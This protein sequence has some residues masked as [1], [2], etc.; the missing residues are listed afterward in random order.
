MLTELHRGVTLRDGMSYIVSG[1]RIDE[2]G[3]GL[4]EVNLGVIPVVCSW[5]IEEWADFEEMSEEELTGL[6]QLAQ[7]KMHDPKHK[8][9][10]HFMYFPPGVVMS[11]EAAEV[12][13]RVTIRYLRLRSLR[14][15][16]APATLIDQDSQLLDRALKELEKLVRDG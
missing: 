4:I 13:D 10:A 14:E 3:G 5:T 2:T 6:V 12:F 15:Q 11:D 8:V 16:E 1:E 7:D 9:P